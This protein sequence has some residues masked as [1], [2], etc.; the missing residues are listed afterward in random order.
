M[1]YRYEPAVRLIQ[2]LEQVSVVLD[3]YTLG[4]CLFKQSRFNSNFY[5][6]V[7]NLPGR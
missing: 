3:S 5:S 6:L 4:R 2:S 7:P 1:N